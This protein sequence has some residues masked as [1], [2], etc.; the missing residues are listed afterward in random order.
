MANLGAGNPPSSRIDIS[1]GRSGH[2]ESVIPD[3]EEATVSSQETFKANNLWRN[4][5]KVTDVYL[6]AE[7]FIHAS[8]LALVSNIAFHSSWMPPTQT[9]VR[10]NRRAAVYLVV[11][12]VSRRCLLPVL[13]VYF[14]AHEQ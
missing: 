6:P 1:C 4:V 3:D 13:A 2:Y 14:V 10:R 8:L 7:R 5:R 9:T 12:V 11:V